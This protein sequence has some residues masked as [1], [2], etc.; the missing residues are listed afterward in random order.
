MLKR[1]YVDNFKALNQFEMDFEP[2][3]VVV[4]NNMSGKSTVLQVLD[5]ISGFVREDFGV[6][7]ERR[8]WKVADIKSQLQKS[9]KITIRCEMELPAGPEN[10][11]VYWEI[12]LLAYAQKN[13]L[14]LSHETVWIPDRQRD[15]FLLSYSYSKDGDNFIRNYA[16]GASE[17]LPKL[18][19]NF[20]LLKMM[21]F[22]EYP[23]L[24]A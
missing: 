12:Q 24:Q 5:F 2:F 1:I 8:G 18:Q 17:V 9:Q 13:I 14:E 3:T 4:G 6:I 11:P 21:D 10:L 15:E 19:A 23:I 16:N 22:H 7:L 20:S